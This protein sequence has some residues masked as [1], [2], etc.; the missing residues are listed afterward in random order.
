MNLCNPNPTQAVSFTFSKNF[1]DR[2]KSVLHLQRWSLN[3]NERTND[4]PSP[5][6]QGPQGPTRGTRNTHSIL[7][8]TRTDGMPDIGDH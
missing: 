2:V 1:P 7:I 4:S 5:T 3:Q 6:N 8:A